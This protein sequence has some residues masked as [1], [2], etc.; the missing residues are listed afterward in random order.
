MYN[1]G[2]RHYQSRDQ[3][4][5]SSCPG[6]PEAVLRRLLTEAECVVAELSR[7]QTWKVLLGWHLYSLREHPQKSR[8]EVPVAHW[9][10]RVTET[11]V[12]GEGNAS[13]C[14]LH[15]FVPIKIFCLEPQQAMQTQRAVRSLWSTSWLQAVLRDEPF[16]DQMSGSS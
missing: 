6:P 4:S 11:K 8:T 9:C 7:I 1:V 15:S 14:G 2:F 3:G 13:Q 10:V 12:I 16:Q 5:S